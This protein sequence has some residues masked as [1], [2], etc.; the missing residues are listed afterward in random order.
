MPMTS[1]NAPP[2]LAQVLASHGG[3]RRE[4]RWLARARLAALVLWLPSGCGERERPPLLGTPRAIPGCEGFDYR[5]CDILTADCQREL[6]G[7][8]ACMH[9]NADPGDA[10]PVRQLDPASAIALIEEASGGMSM[11]DGVDAMSDTAFDEAAFRAEVRG[12]E[13]IGLLDAGTIETPSDVVDATVDDLLA[14]YFLP[15]REV[16]IID[17]GEPVDD[18]DANAVLAHEFVHAL[19]DRRHDLASFGEALD[20]DGS[21]AR[22]SLIEGEATLYQYVMYFAYLGND[23]RA[24]NFRAFFADL[25]RFASERTLEVGSPALTADSIFPYTFGTRF[26][27]QHWLVGGSAAVEA[28][29]AAPPRSSWEVLGGDAATEIEAFAQAPAPLA[30]YSAVSDDV[31][32]AW[33]SVAM[34]AGLPGAGDVAAELPELASRWRGDR[35]WIYDSPEAGVA[36]LWAIEWSSADA[37]QRFAE[38]ASSLAPAGATLRLDTSGS[39]TR[40]TAAERG[41]D[42]EGWQ[43]RFGEAL[44]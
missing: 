33:V 38:L 25:T 34:L 16:V 35:M 43:V 22:S 13:L 20:S 26:A 12:L 10:P 11:T 21:L 42:V 15:T 27:G 41:E 23:V 8:A 37:A 31:A 29:Y 4:G 44:P 28:L 19:Q 7:L 39:S 6:F 40:I 3:S 24:V 32:G 30:G 17:R 1:V 2:A 18:L 36:T 5:T 14:Y 9:G